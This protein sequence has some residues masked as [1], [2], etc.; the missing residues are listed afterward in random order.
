MKDRQRRQRGFGA[1]DRR[2]RDLGIAGAG[3][4]DAIEIARIALEVWIDLDNDLV[5]VALGVDRADLA[6]CERVVQGGVD[7]ADVNAVRGS[8]LAVDLQRQLQAAGI[9]V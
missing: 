3:D 1:Y 9:K 7:V 8:G 5:L 2:Q 6:L 4:K